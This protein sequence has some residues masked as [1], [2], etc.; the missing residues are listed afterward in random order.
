MWAKVI[1]GL[2]RAISYRVYLEVILGLGFGDFQI[3]VRGPFRN[4][5]PGVCTPDASQETLC[6]ICHLYHDPGIFLEELSLL[7]L[8]QE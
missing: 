1:Q 7:V 3:L 6:D 2:F 5:E 4:P 8:S